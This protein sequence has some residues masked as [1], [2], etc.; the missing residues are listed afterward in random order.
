MDEGHGKVG[1]EKSYRAIAEY[2]RQ[3]I[4]DDRYRHGERLPSEKELSALF[5][6]SRSSVREALTALE[7][8]GQIEVRGGSGYYV[9]GNKTVTD[10][11]PVKRCHAKVILSADPSWGIKTLKSLLQCGM[12]GVCMS[13]E[14]Q[15]SAIWSR[16]VRAVWQAAHDATALV[17]I[18][19]EFSATDPDIVAK[20]QLIS[21]AKM[22]AIII[23][24]VR[25]VEDVLVVRRAL[26]A[27][28]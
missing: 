10:D 6:V 24:G 28:G 7:Y 25:S 4:E 17:P 22:D 12:D 26:D 21:A 19:A 9:A 2:L 27:V 14:N 11:D 5:N 23:T 18:L 8:V 13:L 1:S 3:A 20:M 15:N 16:Q